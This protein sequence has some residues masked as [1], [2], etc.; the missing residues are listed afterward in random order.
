MM[1]IFPTCLLLI[2]MVNDAF[3]GASTHRNNEVPQRLDQGLSL[4]PAGIKSLQA[5]GK[6]GDNAACVRL[7]MYY[8]FYANNRDA[9]TFWFEQAARNGHVQSQYN[10]GMRLML[11][12]K[13]PAICREARGWFQ[14][15]LDSGEPR[16][17]KH[18]DDLGDC[19]GV[20]PTA[21]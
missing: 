11:K 12:V 17:R 8:D 14:M 1:S 4:T 15:A 5:K 18:V 13:D 6:A 10:L 2:A 9:A 20:A 16:A 19:A 3:I 7:A 21:R